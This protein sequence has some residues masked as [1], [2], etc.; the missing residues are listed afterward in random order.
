MTLP[1]SSV[2]LRLVPC[3]WGEAGVFLTHLS[4][5]IE[6]LAFHCTHQSTLRADNKQNTT[7]RR[8]AADGQRTSPETIQTQMPDHE[9]H[10]ISRQSLPH[11][12][13]ITKHDSF[14]GHFFAAPLTR[15]PRTSE[16]EPVLEPPRLAPA[17]SHLRDLGSLIPGAV[18]PIPMALLLRQ[19]K[20]SAAST[21]VPA[22]LLSTSA[23]QQ[24]LNRSV[25]PPSP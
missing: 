9:T 22:R 2:A 7:E 24:S 23:L 18:D 17:P 15:H 25:R 4:S 8:L 13:C 5:D 1:G 10:T 11:P 3:F 12:L 14:G 20:R 16:F 21:A 19:L 6:G